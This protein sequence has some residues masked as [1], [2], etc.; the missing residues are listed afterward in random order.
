MKAGHRGEEKEK[1]RGDQTSFLPT[2]VA[3]QGGFTP[4]FGFALP[5][6]F[7]AAH[8]PPENQGIVRIRSCKSSELIASFMKNSTQ[9]GSL[10]SNW[11][12]L[13]CSI[14]SQLRSG[15]ADYVIFLTILCDIIFE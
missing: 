2:Q 12:S 3:S 9:L 5:V 1:K 6:P 14:P 11:V 8:F 10:D 7:T 4:I 15:V 13:L